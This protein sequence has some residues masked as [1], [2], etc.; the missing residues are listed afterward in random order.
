[1]MRAVQLRLG[2][3]HC[4]IWNVR[5][6]GS[7]EVARGARLAHHSELIRS[8]V[9]RYASI[10]RYS[11]CNYAEIGPFCSIAWD[12]T[13]GATGHPLDHAST[14]AFPYRRH[15]GGFADR[16]VDVPRPV[17][18]L[19][20]DVWVGA[21]A[22]VLPGVMVGCGAVVGAGAVVN[23]DVPPYGVAVGV[24][25]RVTRTRLPE[26]LVERLLRV[27]WWDWP[28]EHLRRHIQLFR[29]P[30]GEELVAELERAAP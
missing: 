20:P 24:P 6:D 2:G 21:G 27:Q 30:V 4:S 9:A 13:I 25:A 17:T 29:R 14:H 7:S 22:I 15:V 1:M 8:R 16:D 12:V 26:P 3:V 18:R 10:G 19:A 23:S 5:V 11:K 28:D